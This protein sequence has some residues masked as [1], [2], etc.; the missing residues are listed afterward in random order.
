MQPGAQSVTYSI[1]FWLW[2]TDTEPHRTPIHMSAGWDQGFKFDRAA[3]STV[4]R[5][6]AADPGRSSAERREQL[7]YGKNKV[8]AYLSYLDRLGLFERATGSPTALGEVIAECD[9][10]WRDAGTWALLQFQIASAPEATVWNEMTHGVLPHAPAFSADEALEALLARPAVQAGS[11]ETAR[12]D[13]RSYV[14]ALT[15]DDALGGLRLLSA[16]KLPGGMRYRRVAPM[17]VPPLVLAYMLYDHRARTAPG[18]RS[19]SLDAIVGSDG[20]GRALHLQTDRDG[21]AD[22]VRPLRTL[23][24][25]GY[26]QTAGLNDV[27]FLHP[28]ADPLE[29]VRAYYDE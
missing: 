10:G 8:D 14:T 26:T 7:P 3:L 25:L 27:E 6:I 4:N 15:D 12:N 22:R 18:V 17:H 16:L 19:M 2:L 13:F 9:P 20:P 23:G 24:I 5:A 28:D 29:F 1:R 11:L 21:F